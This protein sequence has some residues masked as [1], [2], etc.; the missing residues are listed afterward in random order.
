MSP[1]TT[2]VVVQRL[3][4][5]GAA[6]AIDSARAPLRTALEQSSWPSTYSGE[7]LFLRRIAAHGNPR[8]IAARATQQAQRLAMQAVD[9]W[10]ANAPDALAV[11]FR[12]QS[13]LLACLLRDLL[14]GTAHKRWYWRR[15]QHLF[16]QS[17]GA[18]C[19]ALVLEDP[20]QLP[21]VLDHL[22]GTAAWESF[23]L[24]IGE[25]GAQQL[26]S[27]IAGQYG[28]RA[29]VSSTQQQTVTD[30]GPLSLP[31]VVAD[32]VAQY[33]ASGMLAS[34]GPSD[35]LEQR[36]RLAA[37]L[38]LWRYAPALLNQPSAAAHLQ[39]LTL[40]LLHTP[41]AKPGADRPDTIDRI[42]RLATTDP[43]EQAH[44]DIHTVPVRRAQADSPATATADM[45]G[46]HNTHRPPA[47]ASAS[48]Q[49]DDVVHEGHT[50]T[51]PTACSTTQLAAENIPI[52]LD[53]RH[54][55]YEF[56]TPQGGLFHLLNVLKLPAVQ[57]LLPQD[58][59]GGGWHWWYALAIACDCPPREEL[60]EFIVHGCGLDD[61]A[62][63]QALP[64]VAAMHSVTPL[65]AKRFGSVVWHA[66]TWNIPARV[67]ADA[68]HVEVHYRLADARIAL[69]RVGLDFDPGWLP[70]LGR[71]VTFH[72]G[73]GREP[74]IHMPG[75]P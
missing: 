46:Q 53:S 12:S 55:V 23:W 18:A 36:G 51:P 26:L 58:G 28:W 68:S 64:P 44:H 6:A 71:V 66:D 35:R 63:L 69:R 52:P 40:R 59:L 29:A 41:Q 37:L 20:L 13:S 7:T 32:A 48:T 11:R 16:D 25:A 17:R 62:Q 14:S 54:A 38:I 4:I 34:P 72:Y 65:A 61:G 22:R 3:T 10:A 21:A 60:L 19:V 50:Q 27:R 42:D 57:A 8:E 47:A 39:Q 5:S 49:R 43:D 31:A 70:W 45:R 33:F 73:S 30:M 1:S 75:A 9:G 56:I 67:I 15:W 2:G 74:P 24:H